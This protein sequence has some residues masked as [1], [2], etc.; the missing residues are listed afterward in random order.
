MAVSYDPN[1]TST[2]TLDSLVFLYTDFGVEGPYLA[3]ME[4]ALLALAPRARV[5]NLLS[6]APGFSP[7][8]AAYLLAGLVNELPDACIIIAVVDPGVG[9]DRS[10]L[11]VQAGTRTLIGPDNGL[12][13][14]VAAAH[15]SSSVWRIDWRPD[16]L[17]ASFH[18]R[19]LFAPVGGQ[20]LAGLAVPRTGLERQ[21]MTGANWPLDDFS[22]VFIDHYGNAV[23]GIRHHQLTT[24]V[25]LSCRGRQFGYARVFGEVPVGTP[26]WYENS[27]GLLEIAVNQGSAA[28][29]LGLAV[30]DP[31]SVVG[32]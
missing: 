19:D 12:L 8:P 18:G 2:D 15:A 25:V 27:F 32:S 9:S 28:K 3:Q 24:D 29:Q 11:M 30:G 26:F 17:S 6:A 10:P 22:V 16:R 14:R 5:L 13:S 31:V 21:A 23:T 7:R 20:L 4:A 1:M